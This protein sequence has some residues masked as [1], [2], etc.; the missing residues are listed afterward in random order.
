MK[1]YKIKC[2]KKVIKR[3]KILFSFPHVWLC[4]IIVLL[5]LVAL[6]MSFI[7]EQNGL[8]YIA[9]IFSNIFA[10]LLTGLIIC[11]LTGLKQLSI[12]K[13]MSEK[14]WLIHIKNMINDYNTLYRQLLDRSF[15]KY[16][17]SEELFNLI[18]DVG[19]RA[20]WVNEDIL[21][22][23]FNQT[24]SFNPETYCKKN[25]NYNAL[26]LTEIFGELHNNLSMIDIEN[27]SKRTIIDYFRDV[28]SNLRKLHIS[29][30]TD[31][32]NLDIKLKILHTTIV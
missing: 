30:C 28:D 19:C 22:S 23:S 26:A 24:L 5:S 31:L 10:G 2:L 27:T 4:L 15:V 14:N 29:V 21:Q 8:D 11:L 17:G 7:F 3:G 6:A 9:S 1:A 16:D 25:Y 20:N 18:Y 12:A 13:L 32:D